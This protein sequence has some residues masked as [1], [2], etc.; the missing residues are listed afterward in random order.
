MAHTSFPREFY[1]ELRYQ[2]KPGVPF[3][4]G[5]D[6]ALA[7]GKL[8][9][10]SQYRTNGTVVAYVIFWDSSLPSLKPFTVSGIKG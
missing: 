3:S 8:V 10:H 1:F 2:G 4:D 7:D 5:L 9:L 6:F